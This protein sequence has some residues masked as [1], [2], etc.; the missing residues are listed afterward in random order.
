MKRILTTIAAIVLCA[1]ASFSQ[2]KRILQTF[3]M[4]D[5]LKQGVCAVIRLDSTAT[6]CHSLKSMT[7]GHMLV[8]TVLNS[9]GADYGH[10]IEYTSE[11][12]SLR[13]LKGTLYDASGEKRRTVGKGDLISTEQSAEMADDY[14]THYLELTSP[15]YP[16]TICWE[17]EV[18]HSDGY[19]SIPPFAPAHYVGVSLERGVYTLTT[20]KDYK[21]SFKGANTSIE[22][23]VSLQKE[24]K[25]SKW[26]ME[27]ILPYRKDAFMPHPQSVLPHILFTPDEFIYHKTSGKASSWEEYGKW[28][29]ALL[30]GRDSLTR[31]QKD[32]VHSITDTIPLRREKIKALYRHLGQSTRYVSIQL[33][34][35]GL[36]PMAAHKVL[37][38]GIGDCKGLSNCLKAMLK[39]CGIESNY[40]EV[41]TNNPVIHPD[42]ASASQTN[43]V[44]LKVPDPAGDLWLECT[45]T[46][47]PPGYIH[48][49]I[50]GHQALVYA[51]GT[52]AIE[53]IPSYPDTMNRIISKVHIRI[54]QSGH[55]YIKVE[56]KYVNRCAEP[57]LG[58]AT[59]GI[60]EKKSLIQGM[61]SIPSC[62]IDSISIK[63]I[64]TQ[65]PTV[66]LS[67]TCSS[68]NWVQFNAN[69][70]FIP[71]TIFNQAS[72]KFNRTRKLDIEIPYGYVWENA[73][74]IN[75]ANDYTIEAKA[76]DISISCSAGSLTHTTSL[77]GR[78]ILSK[79]ERSIL[80]GRNPKE[81]VGEIKGFFG[82]AAGLWG[83]KIILKRQ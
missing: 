66:E 50:A 77:Q 28:Q 2:P 7:T 83:K 48:S 82:A 59:L 56:E 27:G 11:G 69:R 37:N 21:Y 57:F 18:T 36:Q 38:Y 39:E 43:H 65:V 61:L 80:S 1:S 22:P 12:S 60:R 55:S 62:T 3:T 40:V 63:E 17:W 4:P 35:G 67:Y 81:K 79:T 30:Q 71:T 33:G 74:T 42:L 14:T 13:Q 54:D 72:V 9:E 70:L 75:L 34:L 45:N 76:G 16:Y 46:S 15:T 41:N 51:N 29:W 5:S 73:M 53:K 10:F 49:N 23:Q 26:V 6:E 64:A 20:P 44:I 24:R 78:T 32:M 58:M 31:E 52:A 8:V 47:Y 25:V 19:I 68:P